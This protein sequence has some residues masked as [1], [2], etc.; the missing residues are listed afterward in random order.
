MILAGDVGGTKCNLAIFDVVDNRLLPVEEATFPSRDFQTFEEVV[1]RFL[2]LE[3]VLRL[4]AAVRGAAFG[5]AGPVVRRR[6]KT[7]NLPWTIEVDALQNRLQL[8][9]VDLINDLE[10]TGYGVLILESHEFQTLNEGQRDPHGHMALVAA[11]TGLGEA[12]L[13]RG[14]DRVYPVPSE[15]GHSDFAPRNELELDLLKYL[16][17]TWPHVSYE[18]VLS[19]PGLL[20]IY[21][22][23]KDSGF[24]KEAHWFGEKI[25]A[26]EDPAAVI[27]TAA[28]ADKC[29]LCA[30]ALDIVTSVYGAEAGNLALK[31]KAV[32][33]IFVAGGIAPKI[34]NKLCDGTF[35]KAF[36]DKGRME[37]L[38]RSMPVQVVLN[39]KTALFGAANFARV[40]LEGAEGTGDSNR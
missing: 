13:V 26:G 30:Q 9:S 19:G 23:L 40:R 8:K 38:M 21:N 2:E 11:G 4:R 27:S 17:K 24:G 7:P 34:L 18:R 20:N 12:L 15:G 29:R 35:L 10:A 1:L 31:G 28:L 3:G 39:P 16:M 22:F 37:P 36:L 33:G 25:A 6:V 32:G 14:E 5:I